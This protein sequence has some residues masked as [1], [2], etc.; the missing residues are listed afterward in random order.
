MK[1]C[2]VIAFVVLLCVGAYCVANGYTTDCEDP[3]SVGKVTFLHCVNPP[4][5]R[6]CANCY[7]DCYTAC[8]RIGIACDPP[9]DFMQQLDCELGCGDGWLAHGCAS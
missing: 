4:H 2:I 5:N 7:G 9:W 3:R 1:K 8:Y 6:S